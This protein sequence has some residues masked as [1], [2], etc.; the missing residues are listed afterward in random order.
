METESIYYPRRGFE[1][2]PP[3]RSPA[4]SR[5]RSNPVNGNGNGDGHDD[6]DDDDDK[7]E[8]FLAYA[9]DHIIASPSS[10]VRNGEYDSTPR[11]MLTGPVSVAVTEKSSSGGAGGEDAG[12]VIATR[13]SGA[14]SL[15][16]LHQLETEELERTRHQIESEQINRGEALRQA[17]LE[18]VRLQ[19]QRSSIE[20]EN[21]KM[22]EALEKSQLALEHHHFNEQRALHML[23][24]AHGEIKQLQAM[25][26]ESNKLNA[27]LMTQVQTLNLRKNFQ[28]PASHM[29]QPFPPHLQR[30]PSGAAAAAAVATTPQPPPLHP[31]LRQPPYQPP[32]PPPP[33]PSSLLSSP[34][35][36]PSLSGFGVSARSHAMGHSSHGYGGGGGGGGGGGPLSLSSTFSRAAI[37][38]GMTDAERAEDARVKAELQTTLE[39]AIAEGKAALEEEAA[40]RKAEEQATAAAAEAAVSAEEAAANLRANNEAVEEAIRAREEAEMRVKSVKDALAA[41]HHADAY[42]QA[43]TTLETF[44]AEAAAATNGR[45]NGAASPAAPAP[46][47]PQQH[48]HQHQHQQYQQ[49]QQQQQQPGSAVFAASPSVA[50]ASS[51]SSGGGGGGYGYG[52][53]Q[54]SPAAGFSSFPAQMQPP[55]FSAQ[56]QAMVGVGAPSP[57]P[58]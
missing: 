38:T 40:R 25:L 23:Q 49:Y 50:N 24:N 5:V 21:H 46:L 39:A 10:P 7:D 42:D 1:Q 8:G 56:M 55:S 27:A 28:P 4:A 44:A 36:Q 6:D 18:V 47:P 3:N 17:V 48:Q 33:P 30:P 58:R 41:E 12:G 54:H 13:A 20:A 52:Y 14:R 11:R 16:A 9:A 26:S 34:S 43:A 51:S 53:P 29:S 45:A 31:Q 15:A 37:E 19:A 57:Q 22:R 32:P 35:P 2:A